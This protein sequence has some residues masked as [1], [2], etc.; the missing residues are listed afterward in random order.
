MHERKHFFDDP[1]NVKKVLRV[2]YVICALLLLA[3]VA[4]GTSSMPGRGCGGS[5]RATGSSPACC[6]C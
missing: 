6:W 5:T 3:D 4:T 1:R 2:F